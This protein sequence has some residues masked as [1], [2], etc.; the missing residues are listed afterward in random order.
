MRTDSRHWTASCLKE[1]WRGSR[2]LLMLFDSIVRFSGSKIA[3]AIDPE[4]LLPHDRCGREESSWPFVCAG[5]AQRSCTRL[6]AQRSKRTASFKGLWTHRTVSEGM[7]YA[8]LRLQRHPSQYNSHSSSHATV[9]TVHHICINQPHV[10]A[11][12]QNKPNQKTASHSRGTLCLKRVYVR[13]RNQYQSLKEDD[14]AHT[15]RLGSLHQQCEAPMTR[16]GITTKMVTG[17]KR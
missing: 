5:V 11:H 4:Y 13:M 16:I 1:V 7:H 8:S 9:H 12:K 17:A 6:H 15:S 10:C 3:I 2:F 14:R